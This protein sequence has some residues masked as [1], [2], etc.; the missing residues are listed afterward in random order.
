MRLRLLLTFLVVL[1]VL[2]PALA[3]VPVPTMVK[4]WHAKGD[5]VTSVDF[6]PNDQQVAFGTQSGVLRVRDLTGQGGDVTLS[7]AGALWVMYSP[8]VVAAKPNGQPLGIASLL[9]LAPDS[10][11]SIWYPDT[12]QRQG[13]YPDAGTNGAMSRNGRVAAFTFGKNDIHIWPLNHWDPA[14]HQ[15][16]M[17]R[18]DG[19]DGVV[20][21]LG[22]NQNGSVLS[23]GYLLIDGTGLMIVWDRLTGGELSR[24]PLEQAPGEITFT[25][26][27]KTYIAVVGRNADGTGLVRLVKPRGEGI[28][29]TFPAP[30]SP[31]LSA[32]FSYDEKLLATG[33]WDGQI[34]IWDVHAGQVVMSVPNGHE[35]PI[36]AVAWTHDNATIATAGEDGYLRLWQIPKP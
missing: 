36:R 24:F 8:F 22:L 21:T 34:D 11:L 19:V 32:A 29:A 4:A 6:S 35:G 13:Y 17:P 18:P 27:T 12:W 2:S 25:P 14:Y 20:T 15:I 23:S 16:K 30:P 31:V 33:R 26:V 28:V 10:Q 1:A 3:D 7:D 9:T 5:R